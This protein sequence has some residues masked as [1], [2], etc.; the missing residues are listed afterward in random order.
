MQQGPSLSNDGLRILTELSDASS[1]LGEADL[2]LEHCER[3]VAKSRQPDLLAAIEVARSQLGR[4]AGMV[5]EM[6]DSQLNHLRAS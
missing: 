5:A 3:W 2:C 4:V 6:E 1:R